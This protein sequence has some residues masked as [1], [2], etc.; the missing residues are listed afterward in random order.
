MLFIVNWEREFRTK[1]CSFPLLKMRNIERNNVNTTKKI[2]FIN[3][4]DHVGQYFY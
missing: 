2:Y 3:F 1:F 4:D